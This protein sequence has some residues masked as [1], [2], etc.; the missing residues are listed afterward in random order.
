M[1]AGKASGDPGRGHK[2]TLADNPAENAGLLGAP[3][4][5]D[6]VVEVA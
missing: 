4:R 6:L 3:G 5:E 2:H 1:P